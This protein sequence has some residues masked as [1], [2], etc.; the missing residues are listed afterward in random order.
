MALVTVRGNLWDHMGQAIPA[1]LRPELL[2]R[3]EQ[4]NVAG[5]GAL[6]GVEARASLNQTT[7]AFTIKLEGAFGVRYRM[8]AR[9]LVDPTESRERWAWQY[10][11]WAR[12]I[13]PYPN[14]GDLGELVV[15]ERGP[16][17]VLVQLDDPPADYTG[18]WLHSAPG[19]ENNPDAS[20]TGM[21][22]RV[23]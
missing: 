14:G 2:F 21:L 5:T 19:D 1:E 9:W 22:R 11:E 17:S 7:G 10:T 13:E 15:N 12:L 8:V 23:G 3:P 20:G 4:S 18:W 16:W 6:A